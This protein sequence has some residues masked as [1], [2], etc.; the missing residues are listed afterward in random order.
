MLAFVA[1]DGPNAAAAQSA[2][3][4]G[5]GLT[6]TLVKRSD[7]QAGDVGD[8]EREGDRDAH[9]PDGHRHAAAHGLR[10][11][12]DVIAYRNAAGTGVAGASGAPSGAPDIY[13]PGI[14]AGSWVFAVGND[15]DRA[16]ARTPVAG[17]ELQHQWIDTGVRRHVLGAVHGGTEHG[18]R[19]R[20]DPRQRPDQRPL[21]LRGGRGHAGRGHRHR[22]HRAGSRGG[23]A[24]GDR[25]GLLLHAAPAR[26]RSRCSRLSSRARP[27]A[28]RPC[29][30]AGA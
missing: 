10:R 8:L 24:L 29:A 23:P 3:V 26:G 16:V 9:Q 6:W 28:S 21:E 17:Q 20:D 18:A 15:W 12:A 1:V 27:P 5:A 14:P 30:R 22:D 25:R 19:A 4:T 11:V 7:T 13:L 2:T